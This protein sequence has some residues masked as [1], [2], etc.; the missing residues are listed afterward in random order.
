MS[1]TMSATRTPD[2]PVV[3]SNDFAL[4]DGTVLSIRAT[5]AE[6]ARDT[7]LAR[8]RLNRVNTKLATEAQ[9]SLCQRMIHEAIEATE[10]YLTRPMTQDEAHHAWTL[11]S[12]VEST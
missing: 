5:A 12:Q 11:C 1:E 2:L 7:Y 4:A 9:I 8:V 6:M 10:E 3:Y